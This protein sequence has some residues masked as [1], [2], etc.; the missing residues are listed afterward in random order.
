MKSITIR[1]I[2]KGN[3]MSDG[4]VRVRFAPS[5]TGM[6]HIGG[7]RTAIFNWAFAR[8]C[9][10][11]FILRIEDTDPERS[12]EENT[13]II[14]RAMRWLGL[15]WDEGPE[16][17][18]A[19]GPYF[20]SERSG[21][22]AEGLEILKAKG[23]V[24]PCFC[25]KEDLDRERAEA[26]AESGGYS[27]YSGH[28]RDI[29]PEEAELRIRNG[30]S[31]V[32][33]LRVPEGH[34]PI[35][36][37]DE[38]YGHIEFPGDAVDDIVLVRSD[39]TPTY[40][41]ANVCDDANMGITHV[42][43]GDDHLS[44]TPKQILIYEAFGYDVPAFAHLPM[45]LGTDG[46]KLSKRHGATSVEE[47]RDRGYIPEAV[48]NY[49]ALLG[50]SLDGETTIIPKDVLT[51]EFSLK[52]INK[53]DAVFDEAKLDWMNGVYLRN[54]PAKDWVYGATPWLA[55]AKA[56]GEQVA[57]MVTV[58]PSRT[59]DEIREAAKATRVPGEGINEEV[60][61]ACLADVADHGDWWEKVCALVIERVNRFG[62]V[63]EKIEYLFWG[64]GAKVDQKS[65]DKILLKDKGQAKEAIDICLDVLKDQGNSWDC[66]ELEAKCRLI[67]ES[68]DMKLKD[69]FQPLRVAVCGNMVSPPLFE[70][71][72]L[73]DRED[74]VARIEAVRD[75]F[76]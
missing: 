54:L 32:W 65:A 48:V 15:D 16:V 55:Q 23:V 68:K 36:F 60:W 18:G 64:R 44:N 31:H 70:S 11:T 57:D 73:M 7:A 56:D 58:V 46:K 63:P 49:L 61:Q 51:K 74:V 4:N 35:A 13:Q 3:S 75:H 30:E 5:P 69:L 12:T 50:W 21:T 17:G 24:Y 66:G 71:I 67:G 47:Y 72:E 76:L 34:G 19:T 40:N 45:I 10:G 9:G 8:A 41:F 37:D 26:E 33:R 14:L 38:V 1:A 6:L 42:I 52:R 2:M 22:Y 59:K 27:G 62:E 20:Q 53:K 43:R 25:S 28:C 29:D 39:G